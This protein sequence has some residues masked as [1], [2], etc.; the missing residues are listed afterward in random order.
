[1]ANCHNQLLAFNEVLNISKTTQSRLARAN[2]TV[3]EYIKKLCADKGYPFKR[4]KVQGSK[5]LGTLIRKYGEESDID[6]GVYFFPKPSIEPESLMR[7]LHRFFVNGHG[8]QTQ[9][10]LKTKCVR[11]TYA[12][13]FHI[14]L[15]IYYLNDLRGR[16]KS[17]LA[18]RNGWVKSD[19]LEFEDWFIQQGE[20]NLGQLVRI[21]RYLKAWCHHIAD[22]RRVPQGIALTTLAAKLFKPYPRDDQALFHILRSIYK[23]LLKKWSCIM[24]VP[25]NDELL[26]KFST[27][28]MENFM[29]QLKLFIMDAQHALHQKEISTAYRLWKN[30]LGRNF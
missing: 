29:L 26:R 15:P 1:M 17:Y 4:F 30:H 8:T 3:C 6:I 11:V 23:T 2:K 20:Q 12:G 9:P 22:N 13:S 19:P 5:Q 21:V 25:P 24:P 16:G 28:D 10:E 14:D 27:A 18:T 7:A